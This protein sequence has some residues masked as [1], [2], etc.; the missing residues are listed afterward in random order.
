MTTTQA[1]SALP[2]P[3][4]TEPTTRFRRVAG[5]IAL[6]LAFILQLACNAIY[7]WVSTESGLSD[8]EGGSQAVE[9]YGRYPA[10]FEAMTVLAMVGVLVMIPGLLAALRVLRPAK[11]RLALWAVVLMITGY[12][13]YFG[14]VTTNFSALGLARYAASHPNVDA[15]AI[16]DA[17]QGFPALMVFFVL[18]VI[19]NLIGTLLLGL[20][21]IL[22][23]TLPWYAGA[24]I[25]CW[26]VGHIINITGGG[27]W[28]AVAGGALEIVGLGIVA[29]AALRISDATW[30]ARG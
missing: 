18:F 19:G 8:T 24:L 5:A 2:A 1:R 17:A 14:T 4:L 20:A 7:A 16:Q 10:A 27:E 30:A 21:V 22:S 23:K 25:M 15:G 11:P 6:P 12:V 9:L 29:A 3:V 26:T 28:F 13:C